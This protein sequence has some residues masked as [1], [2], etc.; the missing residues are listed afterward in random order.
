M[1]WFDRSFWDI[2]QFPMRLRVKE[3]NNHIYVA[4]EDE[5]DAI[6]KASRYNISQLL[7]LEQHI[8]NGCW[9]EVEKENGD[10]II[11][12]MEGLHET[13]KVKS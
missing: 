4:C 10:T 12:V 9:E 8:G 3:N 13:E 11:E 6:K 7:S 5:A 1:A 2:E